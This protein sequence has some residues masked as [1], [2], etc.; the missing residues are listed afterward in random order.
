MTR[1]QEDHADLGERYGE[2][3]TEYF[4]PRRTPDT[5]KT[6]ESRPA[7]NAISDASEPT[8]PKE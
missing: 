2:P 4:K 3:V 8:N 7:R 6:P 5:K 1:P